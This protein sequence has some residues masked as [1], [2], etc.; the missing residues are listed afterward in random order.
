MS[1]RMRRGGEFGG[2]AVATAAVQNVVRRRTAKILGSRIM[3][4]IPLV[5]E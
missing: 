2:V 5:G 3:L 4:T 1:R